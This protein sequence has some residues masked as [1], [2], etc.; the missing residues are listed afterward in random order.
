MISGA[1]GLQIIISTL[2]DPDL[3]HLPSFAATPGAI[4]DKAEA[5][6]CVS[7]SWPGQAA[8]AAAALLKR[9]FGREAG[10]P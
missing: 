5:S 7:F 3:T 10:A 4:G 2:S 6:L 1:V 8:A 9:L